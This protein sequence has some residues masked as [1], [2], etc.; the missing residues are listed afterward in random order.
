MIVI[1][2]YLFLFIFG[3]CIG[4]VLEVVYRSIR[5][6]QFV[7]PGFLSGPYLPLYGF[8]VILLH[9]F[10]NLD[11][12]FIQNTVL[13]MIFYSAVVTVMLTAIELIAGLIFINALKIKLWDYSSR[14]LNFKGI[15]C[16]LFT[17]I[18]GVLG[19]LYYS[20][21][22][23]WLAGVSLKIA[24]SILMVLVIGI[25]YGIFFFDLYGALNISLKIRQTAS[26]I[27]AVVNYE[28]LKN[29]YKQKVRMGK[30]KTK[31]FLPFQSA[32][33]FSERLQE[34]ISESKIYKAIKRKKG[35]EPDSQPTENNKKDD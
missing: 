18:W 23:P 7:N 34:S 14:P 28:Q 24:D 17:V 33:A 10:S 13:Q 25:I 30:S 26:K 27:K 29:I 32:V 4:W 9:F 5:Y 2:Q 19:I 31:F 12:S 1:I 35:E 8:G 21:V 6:K 15:I 11:Y 20:L 16:P 22:N 3:A